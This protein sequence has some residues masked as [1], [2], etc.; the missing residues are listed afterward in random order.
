MVVNPHYVG[1]SLVGI[2]VCAKQFKDILVNNFCLQVILYKFQLPF[3]LQTNLEFCEQ[4]QY[5]QNELTSDVDFALISSDLIQDE[6]L[7]QLNFEKAYKRPVK[8]T[9][10]DL[11]P[12][13]FICGLLYSSTHCDAS[14][15][16]PRISFNS[17]K[18]VTRSNHL[19]YTF[20]PW[21]ALM[22]NVNKWKAQ[23]TTSS[24]AWLDPQFKT[25]ISKQKMQE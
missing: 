16:A 15:K 17:V 13:L 9:K 14:K 8:L 12:E 2:Y 24:N 11:I 22:R 18:W 21:N 1:T 20:V 4:E 7:R 6:L 3:H 23:L 25:P 10:T 19:H 5:I